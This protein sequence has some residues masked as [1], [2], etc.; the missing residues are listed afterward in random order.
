MTDRSKRK[1]KGEIEAKPVLPEGAAVFLKFLCTE[2]RV[3]EFGSGG[4][5][6]WLSGFIK[7]LLSIEDDPDWYAAVRAGLSKQ[8]G[9]DAVWLVPEGEMA[10]AIDNTGEWDVVFVD[11]L[12]NKTRRECILRSLNHVKPGGWLVADDYNFPVVKRTIDGLPSS[13]WSTVIMRGKKAHPL[14]EKIVTTETAF[15]HKAVL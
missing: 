7:D 2:A 11:C 1:P 5:T 3:F 13:M 6:L 9:S 12:I 14:S 4:S 10:A 15:C 8:G